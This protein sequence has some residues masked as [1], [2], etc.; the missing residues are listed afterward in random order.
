MV[1]REPRGA[2]VPVDGNPF[3]IQLAVGA[4]LV[5][6][7]ALAASG[8]PATDGLAR[9]ALVAL[10]VAT[11]S[12]VTGSWRAAAATAVVAAL[13]MNGFLVDRLGTL[14]WHG[15]PDAGRLA[16]LA[17]AAVTGLLV[18]RPTDG[19]EVRTGAGPRLHVVKEENRG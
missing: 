18:R 14:A 8:V 4:G 13:V 16:V 2:D 19:I 15:A 6:V 10:P 7:A 1:R 11:V 3:G 12:V 17:V 5:V 9:L